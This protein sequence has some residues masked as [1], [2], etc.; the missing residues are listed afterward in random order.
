MARSVIKYDDKEVGVVGFVR[1]QSHECTGT[2]AL[3]E[4]GESFQPLWSYIEHHGI[5]S[6]PYD[7]NLMD[8]FLWTLDTNGL[9]RNIYFPMVFEN[10]TASWRWR[11]PR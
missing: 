5:E 10:G 7:D 4:F 8:D 6:I 9:C 11:L 3:T 1:M 2:I